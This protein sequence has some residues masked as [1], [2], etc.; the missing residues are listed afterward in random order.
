MFKALRVIGL[1]EGISVLVLF[2]VAMPLKY[3]WAMPLAVKYAGWSHGLLFMTFVGA[4]I[5]AAGLNLLQPMRAFLIVILANIPFGFIFADRMI[6][7]DEHQQAQQHAGN[8]SS[9]NETASE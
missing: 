5:I 8:A 9:P 6:A 3:I 1:I 4:I 2:F 7:A